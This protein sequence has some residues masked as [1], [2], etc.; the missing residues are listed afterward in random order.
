MGHEVSSWSLLMSHKCHGWMPS[1]VDCSEDKW[2]GPGRGS[3]P[4]LG[5]IPECRALAD[6]CRLPRGDGETTGHTGPGMEIRMTSGSCLCPVAIHHFGNGNVK[7][8]ISSDSLH[9]SATGCSLQVDE[10]HSAR[11]K[12]TAE[13]ADHS[14]LIRSLVVK[15][16]DARL[17]GDMWVHL[18]QCKVL[19]KW[20]LKLYAWQALTVT[21]R[22]NMMKG[23][24]ELYGLNRELIS[25]YQIR[26]NNHQEL[27]SS[28]K[29]VNQMIQKAGK[30]RGEFIV[31]KQN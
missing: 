10:R 23:Y 18:L 5:N 31:R 20:M 17:M 28:L 2:H 27:L 26:C 14:N 6:D 24:T 21:C 30:L 7:I 4:G 25:G 1:F 11:Q 9:C 13:M 29:I 15:A 22:K 12:L 16:E 8:R 19:H 3:D